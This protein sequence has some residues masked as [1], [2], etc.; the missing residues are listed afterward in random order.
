MGGF[1]RKLFS[2]SRE[3]RGAHGGGRT[4]PPQG[5]DRDS[6]HPWTG[7]EFAV[8]NF[9]FAD[10]ILNLREVLAVD[11][12]I[13]AETFVAAAGAIAGHAAQRTLFE[14]L[15]RE[16]DGKT[17][18][19]LKV[20]TTAGGA[21]YWFGDPI[22]DALMA[23]VPE[24]ADLRLWSMGCGAALT[25][26]LD[27]SALPPLEPMFAHVSRVIGNGEA[28]MPSCPQEHWPHAPADVLLRSLWPLALRCFEG[29][30]SSK[31]LN[32][33]VVS[34]YW[35]PVVAAHVAANV[36]VEVKDVL[37]PDLALTILMETAIH[38]SKVDPPTVPGLQAG[39]L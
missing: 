8:C 5:G 22:N 33:P 25:A 17:I 26:G 34:P 16:E 11:G 9:A 37:A 18:G 27:R 32:Q 19:E 21:K 4:S 3:P 30:L 15:A 36:V 6:R 10:L 1:F 14:R 23:L 29:H 7:P 12:R 28:A 2:S 24:E 39:S 13:H 31:V 20:L 38:C 35:R